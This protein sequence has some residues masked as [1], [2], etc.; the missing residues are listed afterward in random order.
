MSR[1][2]SFP[3]A[4]ATAAFLLMLQPAIGVHPAQ[5]GMT[6]EDKVIF[7]TDRCDG[8]VIDPWTDYVS[9]LV[10]YESRFNIGA[11]LPEPWDLLFGWP[12]TPG[13]S[14][15]TIRLD[16]VD[17]YYGSNTDGGG[18]VYLQPPEDVDSLTN[19]SRWQMG[20]IVVTQ[21]LQIVTGTTTGN[22]DTV[23]IGYEILNTGHELHE[24]GVRVLLDVEINNNDG[25]PFRVPGLPEAITTETEL[26]PPDIPQYYQAFFD[27]DD[28][29]HVAQGTL[30]GGGATFPDRF[31]MASWPEIV[32]TWWDYDVT[33][34]KIFGT[35]DYPDSAVALYW[36]PQTLQP[37]ESRSYATY[38]GIGGI[39]GSADLSISGPGQL[40]VV[41]S[42]W[43]PNPFTVVA[44]LQNN[45]GQP[46]ANDALTLD[47]SKAPGLVLAAGESPNHALADLQPG[48]TAQT[49]WSV[50]A[51]APGTWSYTVSDLSTPPLTA[52]RS[53]IV[54][55]ISADCTPH[56]IE[57]C[58]TGRP[59]I[60]SP[61]VRT[62]SPDGFWGSCELAHQP[63]PEK[64]SDG[65]DND[66]DGAS[67]QAD[68]DCA[69]Q[70]LDCRGAHP[71][72]AQLWPPNN[73]LIP[74]TIEGILGGGGRPAT[75]T[76]EAITQDEP[77][78]HKQ[79]PDASGVGTPLARLRAQR[80]GNGNGGRVY[81][82]TFT[83][84]E[85]GRGGCRGSVSVCVP[86]DAAHPVC[87][88]DGQ[89]YDS[90]VAPPEP[91]S[92]RRR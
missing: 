4:T 49:S 64:C 7:A 87:I 36:F 82:V 30:G 66:C 12:G 51:V 20:E 80:L 15:T 81:N 71:G 63:D 23:K 92:D 88:D 57:A 90:T 34:N 46:I 62:C 11:F 35:T 75:I 48:A 56:A 74:V 83:A 89:R 42:R 85:P 6:R 50:D 45:T 78:K 43:S 28:A 33:P 44:Y 72:Q 58:Q 13:T 21:T 86:H 31:V 22:P 61:G 17:Y 47:L 3:R 14:F 29:Q 76:V 24:V 32:Y 55:A 54:P 53:I 84:G 70:Q 73:T 79:G 60:C 37:G 91:G 41:G 16:G 77:V 27:L 65:I 1:F 10:D 67:D 26:F 2:F 40:D 39:S 68:S 19:L 59:G 8:P 18:A 25:A 52:A 9:I 69:P 38:Y 5:A